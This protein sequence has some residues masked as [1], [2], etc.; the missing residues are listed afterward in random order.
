MVIDLSM[1]VRLMR[2]LRANQS[3]SSALATARVPSALVVVS[4]EMSWASS[5]SWRR[6]WSTFWSKV[7][8]AGTEPWALSVNDALMPPAR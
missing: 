8:S 4:P 7:S 6:S 2:L 3:P 5:T 1:F